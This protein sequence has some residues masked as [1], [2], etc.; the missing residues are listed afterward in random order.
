MQ[1]PVSAS[2]SPRKLPSWGD[3][4]PTVKSA[5]ILTVVGV[6]GII[7]GQIFT[8]IG[9]PKIA[10]ACDGVFYA[11]LLGGALLWRIKVPPTS[12][13]NKGTASAA[14]PTSQ[15]SEDIIQRLIQQTTPPAAAVDPAK[16]K[17]PQPKA[18]AKAAAP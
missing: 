8:R 17:P 1:A 14:K 6:A 13:D 9:K 16:P 11:A 4:I 2:L 15:L 5:L 7:F 10:F 3:N 18:T 12:E